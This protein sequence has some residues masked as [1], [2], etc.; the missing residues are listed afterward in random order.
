[1]HQTRFSI[2][3]VILITF[4]LIDSE[5][6]AEAKA[7]RKVAYLATPR[8]AAEK[9]PTAQEWFNQFDAI[10]R[11]AQ[12]PVKERNH[13]AFLMM[14]ALAGVSEPREFEEANVILHG[15]A[16]RHKRAAKELVGLTPL[17][18][19]ESLRSGYIEWF[20]GNAKLCEDCITLR[21]VDAAQKKY[22]RLNQDEVDLLMKRKQ[23]LDQIKTACEFADLFIRTRSGVPLANRNE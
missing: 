22:R 19:T 10:Q 20:R 5:L 9:I 18:A 17:V 23:I 21:T 3:F 8:A 12:I 15:I 11:E 16:E 2:P 7:P 14:R 1:M 13:G 4:L 6:I